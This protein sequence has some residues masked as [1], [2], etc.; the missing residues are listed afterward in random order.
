MNGPPTPGESSINGD[1]VEG[2]GGEIRQFLGAL[3]F[4]VGKTKITLKYTRDPY[5]GATYADIHIFGP[6][7]SR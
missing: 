5:S 2:I 6:I 3:G 4:H 7:E 1:P